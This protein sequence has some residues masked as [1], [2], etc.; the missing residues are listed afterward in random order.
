MKKKLLCLFQC[1]MIVTLM[2]GCWSRKEPKNLSMVNSVLYDMKENGDRQIVVE[3]M[4]PTAQAGSKGAG[5]EKVS[6]LTL[7]IEGTTAPE[8]IRNQA[9]FAD[10][11]LFGGLNRAR[12]FSE[13]LSKKGVSPILDYLSRDSLTDET[14]LMVVIQ[15]E[16][17]KSVYTCETG[18]SDMVGDYLDGLSKTQHK[19]TCESVFI[20]T[21]TFIKDYYD[22]GKQPVMGLVKIVESEM[23]SSDTEQSGSQGA[24]NNSKKKKY[25]KYEGLAAFKDDKLV[26]YMNGLEARAY[27]ILI[28]DFGRA[29]VSLPIEDDISVVMIE[30]TKCKIKTKIT[31]QK[32]EIDVNIQAGLLTI[33]K[34]NTIDASESDMIK[35]VEQAF[36]KK[37][38]AEIKGAIEKAQQEFKSDIFGFGSFVHMQ[39]PKQWKEIKEN[40]NDFFSKAKI[41]VTVE[42][43]VMREGH[44]KLPFAMKERVDE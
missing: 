6:S 4:N 20:T 8:A 9:K 2:S 29:A 23:E 43:S 10:R 3:I 37:M 32:A 12:I 39:N 24:Q 36:N 13:K 30:N 40:W 33:Q 22:D 11:I 15:D 14:P 41:N 25:L 1:M 28:N 19:A 35:M 44:S 42:S 26:G 31:D 27:N 7:L 34:M 38:E 21:L 5:S 17:P 16:D 18:L